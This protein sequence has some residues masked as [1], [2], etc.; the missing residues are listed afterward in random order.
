LIRYAH[1][2]G[3]RRESWAVQRGAQ[4]EWVG[5][6]SKCGLQIVESDLTDFVQSLHASIVG[7]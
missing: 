4:R 7:I 3:A 2:E 5:Y 1:A 6:W